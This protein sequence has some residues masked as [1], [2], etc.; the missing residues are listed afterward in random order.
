[1]NFQLGTFATSKL[2]GL[3]SMAMLLAGGFFQPTKAQEQVDIAIRYDVRPYVANQGS[4]GM[5]IDIVKAVFAEMDYTPNFVQMPRVRMI[6]S[7]NAG[8]MDGVLTSNVTVPGEGCLTNWY[9]QHQNVGFTLTSSDVAFNNLSDVAQH[10][11]I[12]FDGATRFL[13]SAFASAA[14]LSPRYV[15]SSD[16]N[17]HVSLLY[18]GY[19]DAAIGDEWI[20][21]LAQVNQRE[22]S[23]E[24][25]PL[26]IHRIL[27]VTNYGARFQ[28]QRIC[29]AF[30]IGLDTIRNNGIYNMI[31]RSHLDRIS[32]QITIYDTELAEAENGG[33]AIQD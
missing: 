23:G 29:D 26:T 5:E 15:E 17:T 3:A 25:Q 24:Y 16:Q 21:R 2:T 19:F 27:P 12:T 28:D 13:G 8:A 22:L 10:S 33:S 9:I 20:L 18:A 7:F 14:S 31:T 32:A 11:I 6:Q 30:N 4:G 1:M